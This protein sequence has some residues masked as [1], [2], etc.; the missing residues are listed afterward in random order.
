MR[1]A[2]CENVPFLSLTSGENTMLQVLQW[3][4]A[5]RTFNDMPCCHRLLHGF[6]F[7][8]QMIWNNGQFIVFLLHF[9]HFLPAWHIAINTIHWFWLL[10]RGTYLITNTC[11]IRCIT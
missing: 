9:V 8:V 7:D 10:I 5:T 2:C 11:L 4:N 1:G 6:L 3:R